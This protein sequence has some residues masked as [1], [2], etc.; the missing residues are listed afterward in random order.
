MYRS[1]IVQDIIGI[2]DN[3]GKE[4]LLPN[5]QQGCGD[6][7]GDDWLGVFS[8]GMNVEYHKPCED[9]VSRVAPTVLRMF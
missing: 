6:A 3:W 8:L 5:T 1:P 2:G 4:E 7:S 9:V